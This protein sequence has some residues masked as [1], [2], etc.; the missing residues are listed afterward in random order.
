MLTNCVIFM[1][2]HRLIYELGLS[3]KW[4]WRILHADIVEC[5]NTVE[6]FS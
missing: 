3:E 6:V 5:P 4:K 1:T 2:K